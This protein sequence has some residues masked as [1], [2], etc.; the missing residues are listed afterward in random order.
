MKIRKRIFG[1]ILLSI[2]S[3][4]L[5][6][7]GDTSGNNNPPSVQKYVV[8][9]NV[10]G[11]ISV[12]SIERE[13][14]KA[15]GTLPT[16]SKDGFMFDG[17]FSDSA[18]TVSVTGTE[19]VKNNMT[20]YAKWIENRTYFLDARDKTVN[21]DQFEYDFDL[22]VT[23]KYSSIDGPS[24]LMS[25]TVKYNENQTNSYYKS[26]TNSGALLFDGQTHTIKTWTELSEFKVKSDGRLSDYER[27]SIPSNFKY[28]SSSYA[29]VLFEYNREQI[30]E[31]LLAS[32][33]KYEIKYSGS[34]TGMMNTAI[35]FLN[36]PIL[37]PFINVPETA[38]DFK[39][40]VTYKN[41]YIHTF[42]YEFSINVVGASLTFSYELEFT[43]IGQGV[44]I[45]PPTF[46]GIAYSTQDVASK[47]TVI[48]GALDAYKALENSSYTYDVK[49]EVDFPGE[50]AINAHTQGRT[51]RLVTENDVFFWN[52]V[53]FDSDYKNNDLYEFKGI[54]DYERYRVIYANGD[55]YD[56][57][58]R[59]WPLS[60]VHTRLEDYNN[61]VV[62]NYYFLLNSE[63]LK[64]SYISMVQEVVV[65][66]TKTF[67]LGLTKE[68][69]IALLQFI[70]ISIRVDV[71]NANEILIYDIKS[72]LEIKDMDFEI[73]LIDGKLSA[74]EIDINGSYE[75]NAYVDTKFAGPASFNLSYLLRVNDDG[76]GYVAPTKDSEVILENS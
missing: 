32:D 29:K 41:G 43:K 39:T 8:T 51:M 6:A 76:N 30:T 75:A 10:D 25:G 24:A 27:T 31:V 44:T 55:V 69:V 48:N 7:C 47:L 53:G 5:V 62:D 9:F 45:N 11:G 1:L 28:E 23:T 54:V 50:F 73:V 59:V 15:I 16:T 49:T 4:V 33:N 57:Q 21:S 72:G 42:E 14:N 34:T 71:N 46:S 52:R 3:L 58:D 66:N 64:T 60:N 40:Y 37:K 70:D 63:I 19:L 22:S 74:I 13:E 17:W 18:K 12:S 35:G 61:D 68:G 65:G 56:V 67:S 20:L 38:S 2:F 26:Q 36:N